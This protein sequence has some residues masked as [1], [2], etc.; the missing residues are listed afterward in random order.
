[1]KNHSYGEY[2]FDWGWAD[3]YERAGGRYYPKLQCAVPFTPVPGRRLLTRGDLRPDEPSVPILVDALLAGM[4]RLGDQNKLSSLHVTFCGREEWEMGGDLGL[5]KRKGLQYH[6]RNQ[7]YG[8]FED[9]L[10]ALASRKRKNLKKERAR[11]L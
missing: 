2:V 7:G 4:V 11:A 10:A 9:F 8:S 6:W 3:A 5:L 1:M